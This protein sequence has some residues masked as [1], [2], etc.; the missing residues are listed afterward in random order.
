MNV[1]QPGVHRPH[2]HLDREGRKKGK[3]Q[4]GLHAAAQRQFVPEGDIKTATGLG[5]QV[6]QGDQH[7]QRAEQGVQKE[8]ESRINLVGPTPDADD[9]VHRYQR[10]FKKDVEQQAVQGT[11][12][13][14]HQPAEN[15]E[16]THVL[17]NTPGDDL[18]A[19]NHHHQVDERRQQHKPERN[20]I[21]AKVVIHIE[22]GDPRRML[23]KLHRSCVQF[24]ALIQGQGDKETDQ[25]ASQC[26]PAHHGRLLVAA[27]CKQHHTKNNWRP[28]RQAQQTHFYCSP[29]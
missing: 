22:A 11:K 6:N 5:V 2:R 12:N 4:Q 19:R 13:A 14:N 3:K 29:T 1:R 25:R 16:R 23:H 7:Q 17:V 24:E 10:G 9:Q 27:K 28:D 18:P 15:Q 8:L 26:N 21:Q 20:T